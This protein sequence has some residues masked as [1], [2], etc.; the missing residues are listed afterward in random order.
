MTYVMESDIRCRFK[1]M[2]LLH[3][4]RQLFNGEWAIIRGECPECKRPLSQGEDLLFKQQLGCCRLCVNPSPLAW[5]KRTL[6][7]TIWPWHADECKKMCT[8]I[9]PKSEFSSSYNTRTGRLHLRWSFDTTEAYLRIGPAAFAPDELTEVEIRRL[10][11]ES[12]K[13]GPGT[14]GKRF[15]PPSTPSASATGE[16]ETV[17]KLS[18]PRS[19][20]LPASR[21]SSMTMSYALN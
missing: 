3:D 17:P 10:M 1:S 18:S 16:R 14:G 8:L 7:R 4:G 12:I 19:S 21:I 15:T 5:C 11:Q 2:I 13:L 9:D 6:V 20:S